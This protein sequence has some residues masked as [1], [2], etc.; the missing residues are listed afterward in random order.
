[1]LS[2][3]NF[4]KLK[5]MDGGWPGVKVDKKPKMEALVNSSLLYPSINDSMETICLVSL[6]KSN[7]SNGGLSLGISTCVG[8]KVWKIL[9]L[10]EKSKSR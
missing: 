7:V 1:M 4:E 10:K 3:I 8:K 5:I 2:A 6:G 9:N